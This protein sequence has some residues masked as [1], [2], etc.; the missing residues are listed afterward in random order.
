MKG[1]CGGWLGAAAKVL[2]TL[3]YHAMAFLS[4]FSTFFFSLEFLFFSFVF[5][6]LF[7]SFLSISC[8]Y[9]IW[10]IQGALGGGG[11]EVN[12]ANCVQV[13]VH[14]SF[15]SAASFLLFF[16]FLINKSKGTGLNSKDS[17]RQYFHPLL[18]DYCVL[19]SRF[20]KKHYFSNLF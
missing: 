5:S 20:H 12:L 4:C 11:S 8:P 18:W 17:P 13:R 15:S 3:I 6:Q 2:A 16:L 7:F 1:Y 10:C 14:G 9:F 19:C